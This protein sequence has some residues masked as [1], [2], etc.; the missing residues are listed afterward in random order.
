MQIWDKKHHLML[1]CVLMQMKVI[2]CKL[3]SGRELV[4]QQLFYVQ[5]MQ[6]WVLS[7]RLLVCHI[8]TFSWG[9]PRKC[10]ILGIMIFLGW[11]SYHSFSGIQGHFGLAKVCERNWEYIFFPFLKRLL[12]ELHSRLAHL[13]FLQDH[14][15][16]MTCYFATLTLAPI[17]QSSP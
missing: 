6:S 11:F 12:L 10:G 13:L 15:W 2:S 9:P 4:H 8:S 14:I 16:K 17:I 7:L 1:E 3:C 5:Q